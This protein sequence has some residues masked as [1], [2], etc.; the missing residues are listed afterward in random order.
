MKKQSRHLERVSISVL[1][2]CSTSKKLRCNSE[3][4]VTVFVNLKIITNFVQCILYKVA[5]YEGNGDIQQ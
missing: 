2:R 3:N 1:R 5:S 4:V